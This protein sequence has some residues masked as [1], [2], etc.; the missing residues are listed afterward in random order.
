[1]MQND[2]DLINMVK[3]DFAKK[4]EDNLI[5]LDIKALLKA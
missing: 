4:E 5:E 1:M 2:D 3:V